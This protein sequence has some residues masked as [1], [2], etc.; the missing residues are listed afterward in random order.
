VEAGAR[1]GLGEVVV[2]QQLLPEREFEETVL[3]RDFARKAEVFPM[4]GSVIPVAAGTSA[5]IG[6]HQPR[7]GVA[8]DQRDQPLVAQFLPHLQRALQLRQRRAGPGIAGRAAL[9][10][11]DR[12]RAAT[13]VVTS[14]GGVLYANREA[15]RLLQA[16]AGIA[17]LGGRL[18]TAHRAA[19]DRLMALIRGAVDA[20]VGNAGSPG[21][22]LAIERDG[23]LPLTILVASF[24]PARDGF[25]D[26]IP[27][28]IVFLR[29]PKRP[30]LMTD[31]LQ[32]FFG[33]TAAEAGIAGML[34]DGKSTN[35]PAR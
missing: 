10:A 2:S 18:A 12:S 32:D 7:A 8:Y 11:L 29:D 17:A 31:A 23:R 19:T 24:R 30:T 13:L 14:Q 4:I 35:R 21:G 27:A 33:L 25:G 16:G 1:H 15:D 9:E 20:A 22:A 3:Y 26:P 6:I 28:A 5:V 34:A